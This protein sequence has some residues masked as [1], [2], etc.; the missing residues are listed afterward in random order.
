VP[1]AVVDATARVNADDPEPVIDVGLNVAVTPAGAPLAVS[2]TA[3]S[4]PPTTVLVIVEPPLLPCTTETDPGEADSVN[5]GLVA[6]GASA[7]IRPAFGLPQPVTRSY[8]VTA[9][10]L[11]DVPLVMSWKSVSYTDVTFCA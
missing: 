5:D 3:E 1:V 11:P 8:P 6:T 4:N 2:A 9:E 7:S 10:K